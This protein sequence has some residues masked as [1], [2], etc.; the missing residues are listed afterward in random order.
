MREKA[1]DGPSTATSAPPAKEVI[2]RVLV[3]AILCGASEIEITKHGNVGRVS[4]RL[5]GRLRLA[6]QFPG[7]LY[8]RV[9][10]RV[11]LMS[12]QLSFSDPRKAQESEV[13]VEIRGAFD[14]A[15]KPVEAEFMFRLFVTPEGESHRVTLQRV[16]RDSV[17]PLRLS[18]DISDS[19]LF[20]KTGSFRLHVVTLG[21]IG[22]S[23]PTRS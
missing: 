16:G 13:R 2:D 15:G 7:S 20:K 19:L 9:I 21:D 8:E 12:R 18:N 6:G 11:R 1:S 17:F 14:P 3:D 22:T 4:Y 23:R 10:N 5:K